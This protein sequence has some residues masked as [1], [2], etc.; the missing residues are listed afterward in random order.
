MPFKTK[1]EIDDSEVDE[2]LEDHE[3]LARQEGDPNVFQIR[4]PLQP[5]KSVV[6]SCGDLFRDVHQG[7]IDL[8]PPYQRDVVWPDSKQIMLI[9]SLWRNYHI[10]PII[11]AVVR[12]DDGEQIKRCVDG[13]Q[14]L[15]SVL[16]PR[17]KL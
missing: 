10:P 9:D 2:L 13:K 12:D 7:L 5:P 1:D 8:S 4:E 3:L 15:T 16:I 11:F 6:Y 17:S 14:R